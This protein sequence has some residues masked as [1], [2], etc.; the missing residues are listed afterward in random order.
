MR[1]F[2]ELLREALITVLYT[3]T[4]LT[5]RQITIMQGILLT[6]VGTVL[7]GY[8]YIIGWKP[9]MN[10]VYPTTLQQTIAVCFAYL[11]WVMPTG[12]FTVPGLM[13]LVW[14]LG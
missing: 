5:E 10:V 2:E 7:A 8:P 4:H 14:E 12:V 13:K 6:I 9:Y 1:H 3:V 11:W